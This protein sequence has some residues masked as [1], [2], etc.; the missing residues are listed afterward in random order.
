VIGHELLDLVRERGGER[1]DDDR[2]QRRIPANALIAP[3][4]CRTIVA[5]PGAKN[6]IRQRYGPPPATVRS[7]P[8]L[9]SVAWV[10]GAD[11]SAWPTKRETKATTCATQ[12]ATAPKIIVLVA[13]TSGR[14]GAAASV[15]R[16]VPEPYSPLI[17]STPS[18]PMVSCPKNTPIRLVAVG[19][20]PAS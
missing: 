5:L 1:T 12:R 7:A 9:E 10:A 14:R 20:K 19:S 4:P 13:S 11:K 18:T 17:T 8:G 3:A 6:P 2:P 15:A 16:I